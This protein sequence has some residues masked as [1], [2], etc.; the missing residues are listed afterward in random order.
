MVGDGPA[1]VLYEGKRDI[2]LTDHEIGCRCGGGGCNLRAES[3][4]VF[5]AIER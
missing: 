5:V 3:C 2:T 4:W 1:G